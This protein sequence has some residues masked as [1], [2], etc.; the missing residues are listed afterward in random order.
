MNKDEITDVVARLDEAALRRIIN[1]TYL[2]MNP[3]ENIIGISEGMF[4]VVDNLDINDELKSFFFQLSRNF[5]LNKAIY[6][7]MQKAGEKK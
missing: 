3:I 5:S 7:E 4:E 2:D 1:E 6:A